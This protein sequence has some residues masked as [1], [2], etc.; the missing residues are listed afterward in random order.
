M[1]KYKKR[2]RLQE[3]NDRGVYR[4]F[5]TLCTHNRNALFS[6]A[7]LVRKLTEVLKEKADSCKIKMWA[8]CFMPDHLHLLVE[9]KS[10]DA[11][12][13]RFV[14]LYKQSAGY[15]YKTDLCDGRKINATNVAQGSKTNV[16]Q[17]FS[18]A[19]SE[20]SKLW[21]P[22]YYDHVLRKD[23]DILDVA[24]YIF[25][26]PVRRGLVEYYGDYKFTG[27]FELAVESFF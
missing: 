8:Y 13:K 23:E 15:H 25:N 17:G 5:L 27:S 26:N 11:D 22:S 1:K 6:D 18:P 9:G 14:S 7:V 20:S 16:A 10:A 4:Y 21:Q 2:P 12:L 19:Q 3:F 24:R